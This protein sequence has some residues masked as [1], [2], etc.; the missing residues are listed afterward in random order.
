[1][2]STEPTSAQFPPIKPSTRRSQVLLDKPLIVGEPLLPREKKP[3][4]KQSHKPEVHEK[5]GETVDWCVVEDPPEEVGNASVGSV[6]FMHKIDTEV[7]LH[8]V[9]E[10]NRCLSVADVS[11]DT[12]STPEETS[13][14]DLGAANPIP[15]SKA[16]DISPKPSTEAEA[17]KNELLFLPS[18]TT[19][20]MPVTMLEERK[21]TGAKKSF[22]FLLGANSVPRRGTKGE[23]AYFIH[24]RA[25]GV[26][27]G[28]SGWYQ[29]G[30]DSA[31]FSKQLMTSCEKSILTQLKDPSKPPLEPMI[32]LTESYGKVT[33]VG[34]ST[35]TLVVINE[36]ILHGLNLGDSGFVC[37]TKKGGE[38]ISHGVSKEKQHNF[39]TPFQLSKLPS[40]AYIE[41]LRKKVPESDIKQLLQT[42][43][44]N[45]MCNDP[46]SSADRYAMQ[47]H[48]DDI[49][50]LGTDGITLL[51]F[52]L[53]PHFFV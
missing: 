11:I 47:L 40:G 37:F 43:E 18:P 17:E 20:I 12:D 50:I 51:R 33:A 46:P 38:Y 21:S 52:M 41:E 34:S 44:R 3:K 5:R 4:T 39:N 26:A 24:S 19:E 32:A 49:V 36:D 28:V 10:R 6:N 30:I 16:E 14:E 15:E 1:M 7:D 53:T 42:M 31:A 25:L 35:A 48:E 27:D 8:S 45:D 29:Y 22:K 2:S 9:Y 23:D 13:K